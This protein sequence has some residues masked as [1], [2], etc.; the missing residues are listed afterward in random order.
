MP[1]LSR[2]LFEPDSVALIG[3][4]ERPGSLGAVLTCNVLA[5]GFRAICSWSTAGIDAYRGAAFRHLSELPRTPELA[6][7]ATPASTFP[8]LLAELGRRGTGV[9][10]IVSSVVSGKTN[11]TADPYP[12]LLAVA[13]PHGLRVLG[14]DSLGLMAPRVGLNASLGHRFPPPG[15][16]ALVAQSG[17]VLTPVLEWMASRGIGVSGMVALGTGI[18]VDF[19]EL[20]DEFADDP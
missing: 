16:L 2:Y 15:H 14:P 19:A 9:A 12:A 11:G 1:T 20:L 7:L 3:A 6:I 5:G 17:M 18:D 4:S 13:K 10:V 8:A